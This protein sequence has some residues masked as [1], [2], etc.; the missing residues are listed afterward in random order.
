MGYELVHRTKK[1]VSTG[2]YY[3]LGATPFKGGVNFAIYSQSAG[4][5]FLLLFDRP[6]EDPTDIIRLENRTKYI[7]HT[8]VHRLKAGQ[9]YGYKVRGE[10]NPAFGMRFNENKLLID[11]YARALTGKLFNTNNLLLSYDPDSP[12]R[13]LSSDQRDNTQSVPKSIVVDDADF[14][15]E[16]DVRHDVPFEKLIIY[17]VHL[18]GFTA[19]KSSGVKNPRTYTGFIEKIPY[20]KELG[21]NAVEFLPLQEFYIDDFLIN[22]GLTNY[23]GYN[24][25]GFFAPE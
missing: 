22:K 17:E 25:I 8:F 16:G 19:H 11:P 15:W 3:P 7:W 12:V 1:K 24:T 13:D 14:D 23:W 10:Y 9:L 20:L 5:V 4:E 21:I 2:K 6:D 18:K